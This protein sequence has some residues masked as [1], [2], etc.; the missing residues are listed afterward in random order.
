MRL[1][2]YTD[3]S[4]DIAQFAQ[5]TGFTSVELS[6]WPQSSLNADEI[7]DER[8][9]EIRADLDNRGI[10]IS[11]LGYYPNYLAADNT[12]AAE[13]RALLPQGDATG[14]PDG[15]PRRLHVCRHDTGLDRRGLHGAL[16]RAVHRILFRS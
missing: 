16:H 5:D 13:Y 14:R 4:R 9:K 3:Y 1:G 15:G 6:A 2:F 12:E 8:I 11:A 7:T 10:Q